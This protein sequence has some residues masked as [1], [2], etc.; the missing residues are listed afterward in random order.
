MRWALVLGLAAVLAGP[1]SPAEPD[2]RSS[3]YRGRPVTYQVIGGLAIYQ[4]D[5]IL[6]SV[7]ELEAARAAGGKPGSRQWWSTRRPSYGRAAPYR[8]R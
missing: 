7:E 6:G 2:V 1:A 4:G 5:I 8:M 3:L